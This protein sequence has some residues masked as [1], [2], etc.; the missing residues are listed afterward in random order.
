MKKKKIRFIANPFSGAN[1]KRNLWRLI[2][3]HLDHDQYDFELSYTEHAGHAIELAKEA[4]KQE[5]D[6]VVACGGDGSVNEIAGPLIGT[7]TVL[8]V[9]PCGSGNGFAMHIGVGRNVPRALEHL[10]NGAVV[11]VDTCRVNEKTFVNLAGIGF[12]AIV[13]RRL[14]GSRIRGLLGYLRYT[15]EE[16]WNY[17]MLPVEI[18]LDGRRIHRECLLVEVANAPVYGYGFSIVPQAKLND[19]KLE[20]LVVNKAPKWRYLLECWRF[21]NYSFHQ[22]PLVE[23]YTAREI[24]ITPARPTALH[25]D[26]EGWDLGGPARF[27]ILPASLKVLCP[28]AN[29]AIFEKS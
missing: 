26:G 14:H 2:E 18:T 3:N 12:D 11:T 16:T 19:G 23:C 1:R 15:I 22:S 24:T 13:A 10:N 29:A 5:F 6:L 21:V 7:T 25:V 20:V 4:V 17:Q 28:K 27:S 9:L 8:G